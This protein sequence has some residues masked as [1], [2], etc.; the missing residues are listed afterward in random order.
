MYWEMAASEDAE[1]AA[2]DEQQLR[3]YLAGSLSAA[4]QEALEH[5]LARSPAGRQRLAEL[6]GVEPARPSAR[7]RAQVLAALPSP[8]AS[9][10]LRPGAARAAQTTGEPP[11]RRRGGRWLGARSWPLKSLRGRRA[12]QVAAAAAVVLLAVAG[13]QWLRPTHRTVVVADFEL[14]ASA[15]AVDRSGPV[16]GDAGTDEGGT[17]A[18][19]RAFPSTRVAIRATTD[20]PTRGAVDYGLYLLRNQRLERV[21]LDA[22]VYR[23]GGEF[24]APARRIVGDR[25]GRYS[26]F[27]AAGAHGR[28]PDS[29]AAGSDPLAALRAAVAGPAHP[30]APLELLTESEAP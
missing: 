9:A 10:G 23:Y 4:E 27:V 8:E 14:A 30:L 24:E 21:E 13:L 12:W 20:S 25:P 5:R 1:A 28:L 19:L 18:V 16:A 6:R 29:V 3:R 2:P 22:V 11:S 15:L 26:L 17:G 7:V